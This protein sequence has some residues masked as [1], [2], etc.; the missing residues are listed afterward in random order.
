MMA[1]A[2]LRRQR[3]VAQADDAV[4]G[5]DLHHRPR[6]EA[7]GAHGPRCWLAGVDQVHG[8]GAEVA[9]RRNGLALP[10]EDAGADGFDFHG[11]LVWW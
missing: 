9:L 11:V 3:H 1:L 4:V 5:L 8:V 7:E 2:I 6:V 10:F